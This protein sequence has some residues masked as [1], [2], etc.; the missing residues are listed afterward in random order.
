MRKLSVIVTGVALVASSMSAFAAGDKAKIAGR[1]QD[2]GTVISQIMS[3]PDKGIPGEI[4]AGASCVVVIPSFKKA[5]F[6]V[7]AQY[8]SLPR[9]S[10]STFRHA[11]S[12]WLHQCPVHWQSPDSDFPP[13]ATGA[14]APHAQ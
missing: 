8:G 4:L 5:A 1:L 14:P 6:V 11:L 12:P 13:P 2:A 10:A 3:A 9:P 7:G